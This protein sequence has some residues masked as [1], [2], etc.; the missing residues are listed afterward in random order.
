MKAIDAGEIS[1]E[2]PREMHLK[3]KK[4]KEEVRTA[5]EVEGLRWSKEVEHL[6]GELK[7][8]RRMAKQ[9]LEDLEEKLA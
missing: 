4:A 5:Q 7:W 3:N 1:Y 2:D 9:D 8:T 6:S